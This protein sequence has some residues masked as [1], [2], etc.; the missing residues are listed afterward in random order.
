VFMD[1]Y[2]KGSPEHVA[3]MKRLNEAAYVG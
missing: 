1:A 2:L 3:K